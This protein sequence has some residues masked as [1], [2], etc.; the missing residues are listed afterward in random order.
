MTTEKD[1]C[2]FYLHGFKSSPASTKAQFIGQSLQALGCAYECPA[3]DISPLVALDQ[4][5]T[6]LDERLAQGLRPRLIGSSLGGFYATWIMEQHPHRQHMRAALLN[7][8]CWPS[9]DLASQVGQ[10]KAWHSQELLAFRQAYLQDL[11]AM[12]VGLTDP[13]R[14]LVVA[15]Q[16]DELLDWRE[17]VARYPGAQ[18]LVIPGSDHGLSDF[19]SH[20][21]MVRDFLLKA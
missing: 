8:A 20:W 2:V 21:P 6:L 17:M 10:H 7:P 14:Y 16:G 13:Q 9:R 1:L 18:H 15:A 3:L 19:E 12:E 11:K 4:I 5:E